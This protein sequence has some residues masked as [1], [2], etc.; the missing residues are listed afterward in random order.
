MLR[1]KV[2]YS[3]LQLCQFTY[4][5]FSSSLLQIMHQ[6]NDGWEGETQL[7]YVLPNANRI[8]NDGWK[9]FQR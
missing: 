3:W 6:G 5:L 1:K 2:H 8:M 7:E 4:M 9:N